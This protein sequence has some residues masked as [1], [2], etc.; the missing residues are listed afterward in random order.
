MIVRSKVSTGPIPHPTNGVAGKRLHRSVELSESLRFR[1]SLE[2]ASSDLPSGSNTEIRNSSVDDR[3]ADTVG[4]DRLSD[5]DRR[6]S[7]R[8]RDATPSGRS[9]TVLERRRP[10]DLRSVSDAAS[11]T[12]IQ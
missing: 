5:A 6:L 3:P 8:N 7:A 4:C 2:T 1:C 9:G 10:L 12:E 11:A